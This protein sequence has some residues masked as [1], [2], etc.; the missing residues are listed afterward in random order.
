[1]QEQD[2]GADDPG[3]DEARTGGAGE[4]GP[5]PAGPEDPLAPSGRIGAQLRALYDEIEREPIPSDLI[6][7]LERL[8][9][10]ERRQRK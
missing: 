2:T 9:E 10:A 6:D 3:A 7:L 1:M 8:D 4:S 5:S